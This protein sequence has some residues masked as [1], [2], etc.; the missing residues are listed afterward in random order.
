MIR[1][2]IIGG[3]GSGKT[4][5]SKLFGYPVFNADKIVNK[6]YLKNKSIFIKL[7]KKFPGSFTRFPI[8][9]EELIKTVLS[10]KK[11]IKKISSIVHPVVTKDLNLFLS[12]NRKKKI[13]I[14][15]IPLFLE[16]KLN[17][18][19]DIIIFVESNSIKSHSRIKKRKNYNKILFNR[20]KNL[21]LSL[22]HKKQRSNYV[23]KNN[24]RI[25]SARK[26]VKDI[27]RRILA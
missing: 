3:I 8:K 26:K 9:K 20:L 5:I 19:D 7:K 24:F 16:N 13:V 22:N 25:V 15:D 2:A 12:K 18:K 21:Q 10:N 23:I 6:I 11:N 4:F 27:L 17:K 14:L 1:V